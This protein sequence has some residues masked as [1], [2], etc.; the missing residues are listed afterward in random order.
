MGDNNA[1][2]GVIETIDCAINYRLQLSQ[3]QDS[4]REAKNQ[5]SR[6]N[7]WY[8]ESSKFSKETAIIKFMQNKP[9]YII[10]I[11]IKSG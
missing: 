6:H 4:L 9:I 7:T 3:L 1:V 8:E 11:W 10:Q 5:V 2:Q